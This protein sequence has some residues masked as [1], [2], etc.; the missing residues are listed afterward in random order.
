[1]FIRVLYME[2]DPG[3]AEL[4]KKS[5]ERRGHTVDIAVNGEDGLGRVGSASYDI[6]LVD[7]LMPNMGGID[8]IRALSEK[9]NTVPVIMVTGE[10][11]EE[12]AVE[13]LK[14]GAADYIVKDV[15]MKYLEL[16]PTVIEKV[17]SNLQLVSERAQIYEALSE[18]EDRYRRLFE[19]NPHPM[20]VYDL[21]TLGFLAVNDAAVKN[22]GFSRDEFLNMTIKDIR[23][24]EDVPKLLE[25]ISRV[26]SGL[27]RAG[28]WRHRKKDGTLIDVEIISHTLNFG[29]RQAEVVL[30]NDVTDRIRMEEE[31]LRAQKLES[32]GILAGGIAHDFN[33]LLTSILGNISLARLDTQ[34]D[35]PAHKRLDEAEKASLRARDLTQQLLTFSKGGEPVK[36]SVRIGDLVR[37]SAGFAL[38]GSRTRC[39]FTLP[40]DLWDVEADEGQIS[41]VINNLVINADQAMPEGGVIAAKCENVTVKPGDAPPLPAGDYAMFSIMDHGIG[42]S[43]EHLP[44]IFD[45]YFTTKQ[46]GSGLG[47]AT[48]YS[49]VKRH[50]GHMAVDSV[51][52]SGSIFRVYLPS[53]GKA[54]A[55]RPRTDIGIIR[56]SGRVL[57]MDDEAMILEVASQMLTNLGYQ[58]ETAQDGATAVEAYMA[59]KQSGRPFGLVIMDLTI[60]GGMGGKDLIKKL[61]ELDPDVRAVVSSGYSNDPIMAEYERYGFSGVMS[62]PYSLRTMGE[63]VVRV[64]TSKR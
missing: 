64:M 21:E 59:A 40:E 11:N 4:L 44:R 16:L 23:P 47:L 41:Q 36:K 30:A 53:S 54:P 39:E 52:G 27:D 34:D 10:G 6:L 20:W 45:P 28:V 25:N 9:Q 55:S 38:R 5:L 35:G 48:S 42:I 1:M 17:I 46:K 18:S 3:L 58:V 26:S 62:K 8:V 15:H 61:H 19:S 31:R 7:Y 14:L 50:G 63:T 24:P 43:A 33:N 29:E 56:G 32:L 2:D 57:I 37:E 12:V 13:A 60:P 51:L 22:Y 49:I